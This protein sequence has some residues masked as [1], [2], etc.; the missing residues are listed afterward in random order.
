[1]PRCGMVM[2]QG[3]QREVVNIGLSIKQVAI[4]P[5]NATVTA[6]IESLSHEVCVYPTRPS[7]C[8]I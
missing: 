1:M 7:S 2:V 5:H 8:I 4:E 6:Y 3:E